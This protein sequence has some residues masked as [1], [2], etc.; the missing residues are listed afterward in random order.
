MYSEKLSSDDIQKAFL[1][2]VLNPNDFIENLE[3]EDELKLDLNELYK[4]NNNWFENYFK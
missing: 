3:V 2:P 1:N 4:L